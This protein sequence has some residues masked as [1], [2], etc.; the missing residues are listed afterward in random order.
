M[1]AGTVENLKQFMSALF[2][3]DL[4][5]SWEVVEAKAETFFELSVNGR[6][7][8]NFFDSGDEPAR[9][10]ATWNEVKDFFYQMIKGKR[11]PGLFLLVLSPEEKIAAK[12]FG[13]AGKNPGE[14][15]R[16]MLNVRYANG[17]CRITGGVAYREF[18]MDKALDE[19]WEKA[20]REFLTKKG[21]LFG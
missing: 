12:V 21:I 17:E 19:A 13:E 15:A 1:F 9:D 8:K 10:F 18:T 3:S 16:L 7:K 14:Q 20:L 4:L 6:L 5:D 2:G 11:L